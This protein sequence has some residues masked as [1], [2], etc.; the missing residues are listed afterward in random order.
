MQWIKQPTQSLCPLSEAAARARQ[1]QLTKPAGSLGE[2]EAIALR[3]AARQAQEKP[4]AQRVNVCI[5]AGDHGIADEGVSAFPKAVTAQMVHNFSAGGAA[6]C[7]LAHQL[8][9]AFEVVN[10]GVASPLPDLARVVHAPVAEGTASFLHQ[11]AMSEAQMAQALAVGREAVLRAKAQGCEVFIGGEMGIGNTT[12]AA[13][14]LAALLKLDAHSVAGRGTGVDDAGLAHKIHVI[15]TALDLH[16]DLSALEAIRHY[17]GFEM[18][19]LVG[20]YIACAQEGITALVDGFITTACALAAVRLSP[21][22][23]DWL[24]FGHQSA[25]QGHRLALEALRAKPLVN[26]GMRL[27]EGSGAAL[28]EQLIQSA[29]ALHNQMATFQDV[30]VSQGG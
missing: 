23:T 21:S 29:C 28:A 1:T 18:A 9:A 10:V 6:I 8:N 4:S 3:M 5:F 11:S 13:A 15:Q 27:G 20:A 25:E 7:V 14:L 12:A 26:L 16:G 19:A 17:A 24:E 2:L 22:V 30:A